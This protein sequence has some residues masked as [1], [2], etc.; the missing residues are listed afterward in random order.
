MP[1]NYRPVRI[2]MENIDR[3]LSV[4]CPLMSNPLPVCNWSKYDD[5]N[6]RQ[7]VVPGNGIGFFTGTTNCTLAFF[8]LR[9]EHSGLYECTASNTIGSTTYTFPERFIPESKKIHV[10][11]YIYIYIYIYIDK[12]YDVDP[13]TKDD[14]LVEKKGKAQKLQ[15]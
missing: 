4:Q 9:E 1:T 13:Y 7:E 10:C 3:H 12:L 14:F 2:S 6:V 11:E 8:P 15:S 5:N